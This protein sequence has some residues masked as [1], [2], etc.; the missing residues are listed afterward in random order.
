[1]RGGTVPVW[2]RA[3]PGPE[4]YDRGTNSRK[5]P[6]N[7]PFKRIDAAGAYGGQSTEWVESRVEGAWGARTGVLPNLAR[8]SPVGG[9]CRCR[10][11]GP[12]WLQETGSTS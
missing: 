11:P 9:T 3:S 10:A 7:L 8:G 6:A 1:M 5:P 4:K 12:S 2:V